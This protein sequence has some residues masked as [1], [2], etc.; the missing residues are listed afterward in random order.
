M[1]AISI[2][3]LWAHAILH[4]GKDIENRDWKTNFRGTVAIH[5]SGSL[6]KQQYEESAYMIYEIADYQTKLPSFNNVVL[7]A[8]LGTVEIVDCVRESDSDWFFG[9]YGFVL[10]NPRRL[11]KPIYCK[12][13]LS[14]WNVPTEIEAQFK[15]EE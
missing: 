7:G 2:K 13:A 1:K 8:I 5:A 11:I 4:L 15:F 6:F 10:K 12:G 3:Q 14:F 9:G